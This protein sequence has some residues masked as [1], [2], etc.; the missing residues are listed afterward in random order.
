MMIEPA[1]LAWMGGA[2]APG[3]SL[4]GEEPLWDE[5]PKLRRLLE[6]LP[7]G[8]RLSV[9]LRSRACFS[10]ELAER[11]LAAMAGGPEALGEPG[12]TDSRAALRFRGREEPGW[13]LLVLDLSR[14]G[15]LGERLV[16][17]RL[18]L[19]EALRTGRGLL[20]VIFRLEEGDRLLLSV[21]LPAPYPV[22]RSGLAGDFMRGYRQALNG[23]PPA[24]P[25]RPVVQ[26]PALHPGRERAGAEHETAMGF[27]LLA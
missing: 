17:E 18:R 2:A 23:M 13:R 9:L 14:P 25:V 12:F 15:E 5:D 7:D 20:A 21:P 4:A 10:E 16:Q 26:V 27:Q 22:T 19:H 3:A 6:G 24:L 1:D 11:V 8:A